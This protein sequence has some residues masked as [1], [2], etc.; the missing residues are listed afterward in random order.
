MQLTATDVAIDHGF[1]GVVAHV[2][3]EVGR[4]SMIQEAK[5]GVKTKIMITMVKHQPGQGVR[6]RDAVHTGVLEITA[7]LVVEDVLSVVED[8]GRDLSA[9][10][11]T[12]MTM[13]IIMDTRNSHRG[14][15]EEVE[16]TSRDTIDHVD[17][18]QMKTTEQRIVK[19]VLNQAVE[20]VLDVVLGEEVQEVAAV[21]VGEAA[22]V[23]TR[24]EQG[25]RV[26]R[27]SW[28]TT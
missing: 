22:E 15:V 8:V 6:H 26:I 10:V 5:I 7:E 3:V 12:T 9:M 13:K 27:N 21:G 1:H 14:H 2:L 20:V 4:L 24:I 16:D 25:S 18:R 11:M 23:A 28:K 17:M 19:K